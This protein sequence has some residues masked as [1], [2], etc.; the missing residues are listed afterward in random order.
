MIFGHI[1]QAETDFSWLPAPV[2]TVLSHL[3]ATDFESKPVG[4]YE[5]QGKDIYVQV[6]DVTTKERAETRPAVHQKYIDVQFIWRGRE[7]IGVVID[8][9]RNAVAEDLLA[10]RDVLFYRGVENE[11]VLEMHPG[12][13]AVF[14]PSDVH[15]PL[16][17]VD[18]PES[19][20]KVVAKIAVALLA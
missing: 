16:W 14:F 20:R 13:F 2:Q 11:S 3:K 1:Q 8:N 6:M 4:A 17:Q 5:L 18:G 12:N 10:D 7:K 15:R 19:V 9:G